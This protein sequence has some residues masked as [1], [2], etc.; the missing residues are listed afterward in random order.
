MCDYVCDWVSEACSKKCFDCSLRVE[1]CYKGTFGR[2]PLQVEVGEMSL[3]IQRRQLA[4]NYWI[5]LR[6]HNESHPTKK[7]LKA[8]WGEEKSTEN[9]SGMIRRSSTNESL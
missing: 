8:C 9:L 4:A 2:S 5:S 3:W 7:V 1:R 6:G